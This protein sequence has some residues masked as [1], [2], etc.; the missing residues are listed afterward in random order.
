MGDRMKVNVPQPTEAAVRCPLCHFVEELEIFQIKFEE[1]TI[2]RHD[3]SSCNR[4]YFLS[5]QL[6]ISA[7]TY[8]IIVT[9]EVVT[10]PE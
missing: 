6:V 8:P 4:S 7:A 2:T 10:K 5:V 3:C 9:P 1:E